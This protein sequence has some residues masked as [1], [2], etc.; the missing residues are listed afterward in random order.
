M[1][2][3]TDGR[4]IKNYDPHAELIRMLRSYNKLMYW[5]VSGY[6]FVTER[7]KGNIYY[8][9]NI[10]LKGKFTIKL[11]EEAGSNKRAKV[12]YKG[13][14]CAFPYYLWIYIVM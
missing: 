1:R 2:K 11:N 3:C 5:H 6:A 13:T 7:L 4:A 8:N 12:I 14:E 9:G 10:F